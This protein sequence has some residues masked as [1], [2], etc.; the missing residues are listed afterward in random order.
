MHYTIC[1]QH[2]SLFFFDQKGFGM[3]VQIKFLIII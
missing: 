1:M 3:F 2:A